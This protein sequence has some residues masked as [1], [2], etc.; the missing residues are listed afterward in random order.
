M[1]DKFN[2]R[3]ERLDG[4]KK[5]FEV[6]TDKEGKYSLD[7]LPTGKY[8]VFPSLQTGWMVDTYTEREFLLNDKGCAKRDF[9]VKNDNKIRGKV[10]DS[11]GKPVESIW[12][13]LVPPNTG[14]KT[15]RPREETVTMDDGF[16]FYNFPPG[17]YLVVV[18]YTSL[19]NSRN[20][21]PTTYYRKNGE[22]SIG[23]TIEVGLGR[24][25]DGIVINLPRPLP[26]KE[27]RGRVFWKNGKPAVG[28]DVNLRD[29]EARQNISD[30]TTDAAG[31][32]V[33]KGFAGR[34][35]IIETYLQMI[36]DGKFVTFEAPDIQYV[37]DGEDRSVRLV[38]ER[39]VEDQ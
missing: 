32:F 37:L 6:T 11:D 13:T 20:P 4:E 30:F 38:L 12:V 16:T 22:R 24:D 34:K 15:I 7:G 17:N 28:V 35:Y 9:L 27:I 2:L 14:S 36:V 39:K 8:R 21:F 10:I 18:N 26:M 23:T 29:L 19:P 25:V 33:V 5:T 3:V 1:L 31:N